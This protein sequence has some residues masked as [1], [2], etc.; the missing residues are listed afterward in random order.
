MS[1]TLQEIADEDGTKIGL[2][3]FVTNSRLC[4]EASEFAKTKDR[5]IQFH[6]EAY[7][8]Y[9]NKKENIGLLETVLDIGKNSGLDVSDL[10]QALRSRSMK[11]LIDENKRSA[12]ESIVMG[13]PTIYFNDFRV[14]GT[15]SK[16]VYRSIIKKQIMN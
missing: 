8:S 15:Q 12:D 6:N 7:D 4:L 16:E 14:H 9:F 13:V 1:Q 3:G 11:K 10:E 2:P 5:F